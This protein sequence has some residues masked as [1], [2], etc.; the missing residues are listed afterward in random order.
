MKFPYFLYQVKVTPVAFFFHATLNHSVWRTVTFSSC[1][2]FEF[3]FWYCPVNSNLSVCSIYRINQQIR[4]DQNHALHPDT[5]R[6]FRSRGDACRRL[7]RYHVFQRHGPNETEF[8]KF[9]SYMEDVSEDLL[10][11]KDKMF[12]KFRQLLFQETLV[13]YITN[14]TTFVIRYYPVYMYVTRNHFF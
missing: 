11:K 14:F 5:K 10:K 8:S 2:L 4:Q 7:L 1:L 13:C 6:P 3:Y 12:E 9:D